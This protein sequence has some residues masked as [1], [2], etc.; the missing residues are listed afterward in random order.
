M[1]IA[2]ETQAM[3]WLPFTAASSNL[4][5]N[6]D[7]PARVMSSPRSVVTTGRLIIFPT[8]LATAP[9]IAQFA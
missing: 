9:H 2:S 6:Q 8:T 7:R 3:L 5:S 1:A 4:R